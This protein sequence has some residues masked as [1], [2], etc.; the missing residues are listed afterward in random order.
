MDRKG[1]G[2]QFF[3]DGAKGDYPVDFLVRFHEFQQIQPRKHEL[4]K[5]EQVPSEDELVEVVS[6]PVRG[7]LEQFR[8]T[9][10]LHQLGVVPFGK[11]HDTGI[12]PRRILQGL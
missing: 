11:V 5:N 3:E 10:V 12:N 7:E 2:L 8:P 6:S 9:S 4:K 1:L